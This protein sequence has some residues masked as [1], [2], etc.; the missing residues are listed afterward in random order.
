[1][2]Y[3]QRELQIRLPAQPLGALRLD[4]LPEDGGAL[5]EVELSWLQPE[6]DLPEARRLL[7][8]YTLHLDLRPKA[9]NRLEGEFH[10]SLPS[11]YRTTLSGHVELYTD[12]LRYR[13]GKVDLGYDSDDTLALVLRDYLQ[14]RFASRDVSLVR[15]PSWRAASHA[16]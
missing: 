12:R 5:P 15:A 9:P 14:R 16:R 7:R 10:L 2:F 3:A 1:D 13:H 8:G 4:V 11:D 6:Q